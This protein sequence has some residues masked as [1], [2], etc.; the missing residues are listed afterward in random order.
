MTPELIKIIAAIVGVV[1]LIAGLV[2]WWM[3]RTPRVTHNDSGVLPLFGGLD[4]DRAVS[5]HAGVIDGGT[6][7]LQAP[8]VTPT[9]PAPVVPAGPRARRPA[10]PPA[11]PAATPAPAAPRAPQTRRQ[12]PPA[13]SS[14]SFVESDTDA[15]PRKPTNRPASA[16][17]YDA[18][19]RDGT[20]QEQK[21]S[22]SII[23][24][25]SGGTSK[26]AQNPD[27]SPVAAPADSAVLSPDGVP[28]TMV[29][30]QL[31]RFSV[32]AEGTLQFLPGR[33]EIAA[34]VDTGREIR[35]VRVPG[36]H[37]MEVTFGRSEGELY[38]HIQLR[39]QTVSRSHAQMRL[40]DGTWS[41]MN[42]SHT[43][44]V[45]HNGQVL[46]DGVEQPLEDGDRIEMGE[47]LFTFK[48]R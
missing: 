38:R 20:L 29:E 30:G 19:D 8:Y 41:L 36:P 44:P 35:F 17:R 2:W 31:L 5:P 43:N 14:E 12:A 13:R 23:E 15:K 32:P 27:N 6:V 46:P 26:P 10:A 22:P 37:G 33:L 40:V 48:S 28:G 1:V 42:F 18:T 7:R 39:D 25:V 24:F 3:D 34:G 16:A 21:A 4:Q 9:T 47:V 11:P 45:V